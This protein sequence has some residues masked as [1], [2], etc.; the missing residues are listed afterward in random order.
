MARRARLAAALATVMAVTLAGCSS[1]SDGFP[2]PG[3]SS[4]APVPDG[5]LPRGVT[6]KEFT[7]KLDGRA[8]SHVQMLAIRPDAEVRVGAVHGKSLAHAETVREMAEAAGAVAAV[9][10]SY[11]DISTGKNY[12]GYDGDPLGLYTEG[13]RLLSEATNGRTALLLSTRDGRLDARIDEVTTE[14]QVISDDGARGEL[15]GI[16]R[17]AGRVLGCGGVGG[18]RL[19]V[20]EE[21]MEE[22]YGGL[23]TDVDELV[24]FTEEWGDRT[25]PAPRAA[26][27]RSST[28]TGGSWTSASPP[29]GAYPRRAARSTR[30][31]KRW[32]GWSPTPAGATGSSAPC[33]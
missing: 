13:G 3:F 10:A 8:V 33:R 14:G 21:P 16:N 31:A 29:A 2:E 5:A 25:P 17:V 32:T 9:N 23:C 26:W 28:P 19:A 27:K 1:G 18:D 20:T 24:A 30:R 11:F 6:Y 12:G 4:R 7:R 22:P 15:D